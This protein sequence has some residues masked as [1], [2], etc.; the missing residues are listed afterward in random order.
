M[1]RHND[2]ENENPLKDV[3]DNGFISVEADVLL[4]ENELYVSRD[5]PKNINPKI[6]L[7]NLYLKFRK[8]LP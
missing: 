3:L 6:T 7:E 4:F 5:F 1:I 2:Y 8:S